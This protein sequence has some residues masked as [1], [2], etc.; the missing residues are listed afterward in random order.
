MSERATVTPTSISTE[1]QAMAAIAD[2]GYHGLAIDIVGV[3]EDFHWHEFAA[4]IYVLSGKVVLEYE[5]GDI[6]TAAA[7]TVVKAPAGL[8]HRDVPGMSFHGVFGFNI[9]P[10]EWTEPLNKP[11]DERP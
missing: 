1:A 9:D 4:E 11:I 10:A 2:I 7:G 8:V 6:L 5:D 3:E